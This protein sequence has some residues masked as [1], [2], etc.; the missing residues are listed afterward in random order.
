MRTII[1]LSFALF[2]AG[3]A[4]AQDHS[5]WGVSASLVPYWRVPQE[6]RILFDADAITMDGSEFRIGIVRGRTLSGDWGVSYVRKTFKDGSRVLRGAGTSCINDSCV[7]QSTEYRTHNLLLQGVEIHK[8]VSFATIKRRVQ[9]G[10][11]F[12]GGVAQVKGTAERR[13]LYPEFVLQGSS[14]VVKQIELIDMVEGRE[15]FIGEVKTA[16]LARLELAVATILA[17]GLK[18]RVSGG[19]NLPGYQAA[20]VVFIYLFGAK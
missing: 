9:L 3:S 15:L 10:M 18:V 12:A 1:A 5:S 8:F 11:T 14:S 13:S 7:E 4:T 17:P 16:P 2:A 6:A 19:A 20:S